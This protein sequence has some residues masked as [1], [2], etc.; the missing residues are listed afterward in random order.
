MEEKIIF[1][2]T[3]VIA[4]VGP[5]S[6]SKEMLTKLIKAGADVFRLN[7]SHGTHEDHKKVINLI[8]KINEELNTN[9]TML[10]DLQGPK[11]R[12]GEMKDGVEIVEGDEF[13]ITTENI[14]G[15]H[16]MGSTVY[17]SLPNDVNVGDM[18]LIDDG[19]IEVKVSKVEGNKVFT[20]VVYG[21]PVKSRKGIN[22]PQSN[23]SAPSLTEKDKKDLEF[24]LDHD[25][26]WVALSFVRKAE[27]IIYLRDLIE[28]RGKSTKIIAKIEKPEALRNADEIIE[29][30]DA[31]MVARGDLGVEIVMEEVPMV[32]KELVL[33]CNDA[34]KPVIIATQMMESMIENARPTRAETNDVANAVLDGADAVMLSA[35]T[36]AGKYPIE[37]VKSMV[38]TISNIENH[39]LIY[40][41]HELPNK[42]SDHY[43]NDTLILSACRLAKATKAK[44]ITG[45]TFSGY[46]AFQLSSNRPKAGIF[47]FTHNRPLL[48]TVNLIW[49]VRG[50]YY[51][52]EVSTDDTFSDIEKILVDAGHL[53]KGDIVINTAS[54]PLRAKGRANAIKMCVVE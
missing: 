29:A 36:A 28:K 21:G 11:I 38:R 12:L 1:N 15:D 33:K 13:I 44:A 54:M 19:K 45:M 9:I 51:D 7:F 4:T 39:E 32:Q 2:K 17:T 37:V 40:Y 42:D 50:F 52:K 31:I 18:I 43:Y 27:D 49:G 47:I 3:K 23:V 25:V 24:G 22:L 5:A 10:Q 6:N 35:E 48:K 41:N 14:V 34:A 46:T 20:T 16:L 30:S 8:K 53:S 26:E